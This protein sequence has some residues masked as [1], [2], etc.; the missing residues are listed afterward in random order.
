MPRDGFASAFA[1][2]AS[3]EQIALFAATQRPIAVASIQERSP[4]PVWKDKPSWFLIAEEDRMI[5]PATQRFM[6]ERM[7]AKIRAEKTDH[8]PLVTAPECVAAIILEGVNAA[9]L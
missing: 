6:A 1:Q 5:S 9:R 3:P 4:R 8:T 2:H 7:G